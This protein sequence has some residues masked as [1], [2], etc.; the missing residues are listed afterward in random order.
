M[1]ILDSDKKQMFVCHK[2]VGWLFTAPVAAG[3][4][5]LSVYETGFDSV[6]RDIEELLYNPLLLSYPGQVKEYLQSNI[7]LE[8]QVEVCDRL[9]GELEQYHENLEQV[10]NLKELRAPSENLDSYRKN[11]NRSM[12]KAS[13]KGPKSFFQDMCTV[14]NLLYGNSSIYYAY[15]GSG[16]QTRQ[17]MKMHTFSHSSEMP[18][19][20]VIDPENLEY[21]LRVYRYGSMNN[22]ETNS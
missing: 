21:M 13:D 12:Q 11:F 9:L 17:E 20:N 1:S 16:V 14:Q 3:S 4:F 19:L 18:R 10:S 7:E 5:L 8:K 2:V 15:D 6:K 22:N